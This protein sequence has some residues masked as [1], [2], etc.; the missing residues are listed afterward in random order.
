MKLKK[1]LIIAVFL[2]SIIG[3]SMNKE[4]QNNIYQET[5][6]GFTGIRIVDLYSE[7]SEGNISWDIELEN[8]ILEISYSSG[9]IKNEH[10]ATITPGN[11]E[12]GTSGYRDGNSVRIFINAIEST[13][14]TVKLSTN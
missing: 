4:S 9:I 10:L 5:L 2:I 3:C 7:N 8:G 11:N 13:T 6:S 1:I 12:H 14:G